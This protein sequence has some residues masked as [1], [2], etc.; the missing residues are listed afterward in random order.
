M[1]LPGFDGGQGNSFKGGDA[2]TGD[3]QLGNL[4]APVVNFGSGSLSSSPTSGT[5]PTTL[6]LIAGAVLVALAYFK[7]R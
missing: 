6:L 2:K 7:K 4:V 5:S 1:A 3:A